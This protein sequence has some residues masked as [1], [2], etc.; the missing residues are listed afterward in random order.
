[1][2]KSDLSEAAESAAAGAGRDQDLE[3]AIGNQARQFRR[4]LDMTVGEVAKLPSK[5]GVGK[6]QRVFEE[7]IDTLRANLMLSK[8]TCNVR[9]ITVASSP[10]NVVSG[11]TLQ[12]NGSE[13]M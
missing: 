10:R 3:L 12:R 1:M 11:S 13:L 4:E 5:V 2:A 8:E 9:S 7:S 6:R